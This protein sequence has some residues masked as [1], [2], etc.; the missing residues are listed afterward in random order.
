MSNNLEVKMSKQDAWKAFDVNK[1]NEDWWGK[2]DTKNSDILGRNVPD[3][4]ENIQPSDVFPPDLLI[5]SSIR[6]GKSIESKWGG[7]FFTSIDTLSFEDCKFY[8]TG[9]TSDRGKFFKCTYSF[10]SK[11]GSIEFTDYN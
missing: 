4:K 7:L 2:L 1:T 11:I 9:F 8:F 10:T 3:F 5:F 6:Y